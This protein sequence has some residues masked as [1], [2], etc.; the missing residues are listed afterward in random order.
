MPRTVDDIE[1]F[2]EQLGRTYDRQGNT[3][4]VSTGAGG[5]PIAVHVADLVV[6]ARVAIG[7]LPQSP[8]RHLAL[9]RQLLEYN[10]TDL[11][12]AA[13]GL[14]GGEIVLTAGQEL[15]NIDDNELAALVG[16]IEIALSRHIAVLRD[17]ARG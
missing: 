6:V 1:R 5:P 8:E 16:D 13:Y 4:L 12:H 10:A 14:A 11:I 17:L 7:P 3:F 2:L 15:E 9:F